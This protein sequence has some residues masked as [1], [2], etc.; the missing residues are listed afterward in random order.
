MGDL[1][2]LLLKTKFHLLKKYKIKI[3]S[4]LKYLNEVIKIGGDD[5]FI[6]SGKRSFSA[7]KDN[8][9]ELEK[10]SEKAKIFSS[11]QPNPNWRDVQKGLTH[12]NKKK[13]T[14]DICKIG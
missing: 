5:T 6:V 13:F 14:I 12:Y 11:F 2:R 7:L 10:I 3:Y 8:F 4:K 9:N 1:Q